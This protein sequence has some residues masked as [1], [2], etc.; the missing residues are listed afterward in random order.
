MYYPSTVVP[1]D[2]QLPTPCSLSGA[3]VPDL[4]AMVTLSSPHGIN[5]LLPRET[6]R[7]AEK[8]LKSCRK[9]HMVITHFPFHPVVTAVYSSKRCLS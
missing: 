6:P 8:T 5:P 7:Q 3:C 4:L 9:Q 2:A 1:W